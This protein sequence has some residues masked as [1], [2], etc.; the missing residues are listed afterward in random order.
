MTIPRVAGLISPLFGMVIDPLSNRASTAI[1]IVAGTMMILTNLSMIWLT[2]HAWT[3]YII[4]FFVGVG[5]QLEGKAMSI[6][7]NFY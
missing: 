2:N 1:L 6:H 5:L 4:L 7:I 3:L